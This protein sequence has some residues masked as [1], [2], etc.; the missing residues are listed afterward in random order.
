MKQIIGNKRL[1]P[2]R[3]FSNFKGAEVLAKVP[4]ELG[5][6]EYNVVFGLG[7]Q[8]IPLGGGT[9]NFS[10]NAPR[11]MILRKLITSGELVADGSDLTITAI[12]VEGNAC[13]LGA[14]LSGAVFGPQSYHSPDFDLP[15]A[16]G[17]P[18]TVTIQNQNAAIQNVAPAFSID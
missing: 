15:V 14:G 17:T 1:R 10:Q 9:L 11:D 16:G 7:R 12:T 18:V 6:D 8:A 4:R 2:S 13:L 3:L 5:A